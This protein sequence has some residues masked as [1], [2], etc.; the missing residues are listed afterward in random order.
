MLVLFLGRVY[1]LAILVFL[2]IIQKFQGI[3]ANLGFD[4]RKAGLGLFVLKSLDVFL[5]S[6][7]SC[8]IHVK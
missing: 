7:K 6:D 8:F 3:A 4:A 5:K 1:T 2:G